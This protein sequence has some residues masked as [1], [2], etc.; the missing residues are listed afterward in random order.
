[1]ETW[2][3]IARESIRQTLAEYAHYADHGRFVELAA[4]FTEDGVLEIDGRPPLTGRDP[5]VEFLSGTKRSLGSTLNRPYIRHHVSS[6][7]IELLGRDDASARSYFLAVTERGPDHWGRYRDRLRCVKG[8]WL[9]C[10]RRV[11][12]EGHAPNSWRATRPKSD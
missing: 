3:L 12:P 8:R 9:F 4:L 5:I 7:Q 1:M 6:V 11:R 2:E 10:H